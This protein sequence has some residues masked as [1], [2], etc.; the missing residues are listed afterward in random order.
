M[1]GD[2][3]CA[4]SCQGAAAESEAMA[5]QAEAVSVQPHGADVVADV[6]ADRG[7]GEGGSDTEAPQGAVG[8][9]AGQASFLSLLGFV[10]G[11]SRGGGRHE[12]D[13]HLHR[14]GINAFTFPP[15]HWKRL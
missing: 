14:K 2:E 7:Q 1:A 15:L 12:Q 10:V 3:R 5:G 6:V 8:A 4:M 9:D 11:R 13:H